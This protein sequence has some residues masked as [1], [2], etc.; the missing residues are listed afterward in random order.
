[1]ALDKESDDT[2]F[3]SRLYTFVDLEITKKGIGREKTL[4][5][6]TWASPR[7]SDVSGI[8]PDVSGMS[9]TIK[10]DIPLRP[11]L[12]CLLPTNPAGTLLL[13]SG[14]RDFH[15][16]KREKEIALEKASIKIEGLGIWISH[17]LLIAFS[18]GTLI[19][20]LI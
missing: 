8:L 15:Q 19:M 13:T 10:P 17:R 5:G 4:F 16:Q 2:R 9:E 3:G 18:Q 12:V 7:I 20:D 14:N 1:M 6:I 11:R